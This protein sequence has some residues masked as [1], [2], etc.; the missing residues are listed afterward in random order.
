MT[1]AAAGTDRS[2]RDDYW[3]CIIRTWKEEKVRETLTSHGPNVEDN[4][5]MDW[6]VWLS[7]LYLISRTE[8]C[9]PRGRGRSSVALLEP[10]RERSCGKSCLAKKTM[11]L[12]SFEYL[13]TSGSASLSLK[14]LSEGSSFLCTQDRL[15]QWQH[16][17]FRLHDTCVIWNTF[18]ILILW[19][20]INTP[21]IP[22]YK[23]ESITD[24]YWTWD[25]FSNCCFPLWLKYSVL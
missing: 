2:V 22:Q 4:S 15:R 21:F 8:Y 20:A 25:T 9:H 17:L 10:N 7:Q 5:R 18:L 24:H 16:Y 23:H 11:S 3:F 1:E 13:G 19:L 14:F 12:K 6:G